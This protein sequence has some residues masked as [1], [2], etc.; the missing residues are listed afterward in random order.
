MAAATKK[1]SN[2]ASTR[3]N[4]TVDLWTRPTTPLHFGR[5]QFRFRLYRTTRRLPT[6]DI[7]PWVESVNWERAGSVR[8]GELNFRR[9][10][11][12]HSASM[13]AAGDEIRCELDTWGTNGP[14]RTLWQQSVTTPSDQIKDGIV[15][16]T[17]ASPLNP[18]AKS[19]A[20]FKFKKNKA[21]PTGWDAREITLAV[22]KRF[23]V[24]VGSLPEATFRN[25]SLVEK[26]LSPLDM[27]TRAWSLERKHTGRRFDIDISKGNLTV[28]EMR[29]PLYMQ[30]LGA[31]IADATISES[32]AGVASAVVANVTHKAKGSRKARKLAVKVTDPGRL[33]RYGYIVKTVTAPKSVESVAA[34]RKWAKERLAR[35][36]RAKRT[37]TFTHPGLPLVDR[38]DALRLYLPEVDF[39]Q[40]VFVTTVSHNLSA[41]SY[42]MDVT[43]GFDDPWRA[44][45]RKARV[46]KKKDAAA[47]RRARTVSSSGASVGF[48]AAPAKASSRSNA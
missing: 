44:D 22:C 34:L 26:S 36:F 16:L 12:Q 5:E 11:G 8:T 37:V 10:L 41:G 1:K 7:D 3:E 25:H 31:A 2:R 43:I 40:V 47:A 15:A 18:L 9:P 19:K 39:H 17:L 46:Q 27:I 33:A 20:A 21:K 14:W 30:L 38:G 35:T 29:E 42:T 13:I 32:L 48:A 23:R 4:A 24:P 6:V 28:T 45:Q